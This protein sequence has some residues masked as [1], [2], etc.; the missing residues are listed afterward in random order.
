MYHDFKFHFHRIFNTHSK[1]FIS[2]AVPVRES[3]TFLNFR[4]YA[5]IPDSRYWTLDS[6]SVELG[7]WTPIVSGISGSFFFSYIPNS[8]SQA[9]AFHKNFSGFLTP[10]QAKIFRKPESGFSYMCQLHLC[11]LVR[12]DGIKEM[13]RNFWGEAI[14]WKKLLIKGIAVE[15]AQSRQ[16]KMKNFSS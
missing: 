2:S 16:Q 14:K 6:F 9:S 4:F 12:T 10:R 3:K 15:F 13:S 11:K 7:F 5:V 1:L 8:R